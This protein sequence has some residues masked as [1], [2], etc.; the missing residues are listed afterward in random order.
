MIQ[1]AIAEYAARMSQPTDLPP[2]IATLA[3]ARELGALLATYPAKRLTPGRWV[4]FGF[5]IALLWGLAA[6]PVL[7]G[8]D[9]WPMTAIFGALGLVFV[10]LL[11]RTPN[12]S[13]AQAR[14]R[15]YAFEHG[16]V[17][18]DRSGTPADYRWDAI[19]SVKQKIVRR[20]TY[21]VETARNYLYT[22]TR[23]DGTVLKLTEFFDGIAQ[24]GQGISEQVAR[25]HLPHAYAAIQRGETVPFGDLAVNAAGVVSVRHGVLPWYQLEGVNVF[26]GYVRLRKAGKWL[27]WSGKPASEI[28]NLYVFLTLADQL[29][30]TAQRTFS[31]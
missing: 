9:A 4:A 2:D 6:V 14:R 8:P 21:G 22:V 23:N 25:V 12:F 13:R 30:R 26:N 18:V 7:A 3:R 24:L 29:Q 10:A 28:P 19:M 11:L 17:H 1:S 5:L 20:T 31:S 16:I 15:V 27:P